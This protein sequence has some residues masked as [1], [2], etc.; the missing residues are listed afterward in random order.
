MQN[1]GKKNKNTLVHI[2]WGRMF[3]HHYFLFWIPNNPNFKISKKIQVYLYYVNCSKIIFARNLENPS[4]Y[5][6]TLIYFSLTI[7]STCSVFRICIVYYNGRYLHTTWKLLCIKFTAE[8][9]Y[10][11]R[12]VK[13]IQV[14]AEIGKTW[15]FHH[16]G[17]PGFWH[18]WMHTFITAPIFCYASRKCFAGLF[19]RQFE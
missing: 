15:R 11:K 13:I 8:D 2:A 18:S 6:K 14:S 4:I 3:F 9:K 12:S 17:P 1:R 19:T 10:Q 5:K 16:F 7:K